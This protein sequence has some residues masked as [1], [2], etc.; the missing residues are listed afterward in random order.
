VFVPVVFSSV[1]VERGLLAQSD[2]TFATSVFKPWRV[3]IAV[4]IPC[5]GLEFKR[6]DKVRA[7][8]FERGPMEVIRED[9]AIEETNWASGAVVYKK[10]FFNV[11]A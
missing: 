9:D 3:S 4:A 11:N 10:K 2:S 1:T 5:S 6:S 8:S 7:E